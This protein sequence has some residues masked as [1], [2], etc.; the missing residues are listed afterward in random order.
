MGGLVGTLDG[1][2]GMSTAS[3]FGSDPS[4]YY[5]FV[6]A[7]NGFQIAGKVMPG[8]AIDDFLPPSQNYLLYLYQPS[9]NCW[10]VVNGESAPSGQVTH[11]NSI[12]LSHFGG[13]DSNGDGI[14]DIGKIAIGLNPNTPDPDPLGIS[15]VAA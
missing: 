2:S 7:D 3:G 5:R 6:F 13:P 1:G 4:I 8:Q 14:P 9:T 12:F 15:A 11:L 10:L